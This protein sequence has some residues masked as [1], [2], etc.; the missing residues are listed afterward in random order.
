M[1]AIVTGN[2]GFDSS[3]S[4]SDPVPERVPPIPDCTT[5]L[6]LAA[7]RCLDFV[8]SPN[9]NAIIN[10]RPLVAP[11][12]ACSS[13]TTLLPVVGGRVHVGGWMHMC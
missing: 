12:A 1:Q 13:W 7:A 4:I 9:D 6:Y 2:T 8:Y 10:V 3:R 11:L 5:N